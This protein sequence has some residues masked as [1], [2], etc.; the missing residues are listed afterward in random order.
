MIKKILSVV[1]TL[2]MLLTLVSSLPVAAEDIQVGRPTGEIPEAVASDGF[3]YNFED[4]KT[5]GVSFY[6]TPSSAKGGAN[7]TEKSVNFRDSSKTVDE[8]SNDYNTYKYLPSEVTVNIPKEFNAKKYNVVTKVSFWVRSQHDNADEVLFSVGDEEEIVFSSNVIEVSPNVAKFSEKLVKGDWKKY[9]LW[10]RRTYAE[11][12]DTSAENYKILITKK[13]YQC[14]FDI[15]EIEVKYYYKPDFDFEDEETDTNSLRNWSKVNAADAEV[16]SGKEN[17]AIQVTAKGANAGISQD[18]SFRSGYKY[19]FEFYAK[20]AEGKKIY[21]NDNECGVLSGEW[22]KFTG[23]YRANAEGQYS[24]GEISI[25]VKD[26]ADGDLL[27]VD[28]LEPKLE[29]N[30]ELADVKAVST[31][32]ALSEGCDI[33]LS[34][35]VDVDDDIEVLKTIVELYNDGVLDNA[36]EFDGKEEKAKITLPEQCVDKTLSVRVTCETAKGFGR[37]FEYVL[38]KGESSITANLLSSPVINVKDAQ[39]SLSMKNLKEIGG[40]QINGVAVLI[41]FDDQDVIIGSKTEKFN[42]AAGAESATINITASV[43]KDIDGNVYEEDV[44]HIKVILLDC[45]DNENATLANATMKVFKTF[46]N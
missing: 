18:I 21:F 37:T 23:V 31:S 29:N 15:D 5:S 25:I 42:L 11:D 3:S 39:V 9:E 36:F 45:G 32:N 10:Y 6:K 34:I 22:Q 38:G 30:Y 41:L 2:G 46:E 20:G 43:R 33:T 19:T 44:D 4:G 13:E 16:V 7:G 12:V 27:Y 40:S 35:S 17:N 1:L 24:Y 14:Y 28:F 8:D 26:A